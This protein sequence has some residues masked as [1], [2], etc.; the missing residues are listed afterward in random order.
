MLIAN[1]NF[2]LSGFDSRLLWSIELKGTRI[3]NIRPSVDADINAE[4]AI[5]ARGRIAL[6]G[7]IDSHAHLLL[8]EFD[9][10][11]VDFASSSDIDEM[12]K[13]VRQKAAELGP[14]KWVVGI[15]WDD[16]KVLGIERLNRKLLDA[17]GLPN[18]IFLQRVCGHAAFLN[19]HAL[20]LLCSA[21]DF[22]ALEHD[23]DR[24]RGEI[25]EGAVHLARRLV[26][27]EHSE[28]VQGV[29][30]SIDEALSLGITT[31]CEMH[32]L[33]YQFDVLRDAAGDI[34]ILVYM[35]YISDDSFGMLQRL[36]AS[37]LCR[38]VGLKL[39][40]D[41]SIGART[42]AVSRPYAGTDERGALL[43]SKEEIASIAETALR[44]GVQL[45]IHA[46]GDVAVDAVISAYEEVGAEAIPNHR[47]R[48]EHLEIFPA[49]VDEHLERLRRTGLI[50]SMQPGF[51]E[52][53]AQEDGLYG[54]RF[55]SE[56]ARTNPFGAVKR[57]G[58]PLCFGSDSMPTGPIYGLRGA[59]NHPCPDFTMSIADA[60]D[61]HTA[62]GAFALREE[63]RLGRIEAGMGADLVILDCERVDDLLD[64][65]V[66]A[67]IKAGQI[68]YEDAALRRDRNGT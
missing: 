68:V 66:V 37:E 38:P 65:R 52:S 33:P 40:V 57:A 58:I 12:V 29:R 47:H 44:L 20:E 60:V 51:V 18:P 24:D 50:A 6:P 8:R 56:W 46:I 19:S 21:P 14:S 67:T 31:M 30:R 26:Q 7:F 35:D 1:A 27:I 41:G 4:G 5:D 62:A 9:V 53:W 17:T 16:S 55:G 10:V 48:L 22:G 28:R 61:A 13:M 25:R 49:P 15:N 59:V 64:S 43:L 2:A 11:M 32:A 34:E 3:E 45:A 63:N 54:E 39:V 42:A 36:E 23:V